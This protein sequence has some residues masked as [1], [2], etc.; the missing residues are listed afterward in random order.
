MRSLHERVERLEEKVDIVL[1]KFVE[2]ELAQSEP[3]YEDNNTEAI[4]AG[5]STD[6]V[7]YSVSGPVSSIVWRV[8]IEITSYREGVGRTGE[9]GTRSRP[10]YEL[11][12]E[13]TQKKGLNTH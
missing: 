2:Y 11:G 9:Q 5:N 1:S 7:E 6:Y 4:Q 12:K 3:I 8:W 13:E 10:Q